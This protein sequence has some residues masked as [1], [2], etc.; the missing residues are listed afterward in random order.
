MSFWVGP[1]MLNSTHPK[2]LCCHSQVRGSTALGLS[3][4]FP[5]SYLPEHPYRHTTHI[6]I[7]NNTCIYTQLPMPSYILTVTCL[8][9]CARSHLLTIHPPAYKFTLAYFFLMSAHTRNPHCHEQHTVH[10]PSYFHIWEPLC[11]A[12]NTPTPTHPCA[13]WYIYTIY[14]SSHSYI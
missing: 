9:A 10:T 3:T 1:S 11:T 12:V 13:H 4:L 6:P 2:Q 7:G 14:T 8:Q 5:W